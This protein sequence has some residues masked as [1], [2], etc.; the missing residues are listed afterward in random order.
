M[1]VKQIANA[2]GAKPGGELYVEA[3]SPANGPAATYAQMFK[4]NADQL[5]GALK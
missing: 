5:T 3:L 4:Y 2:T 1:T